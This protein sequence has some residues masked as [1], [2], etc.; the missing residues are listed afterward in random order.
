MKELDIG[1]SLN[2]QPSNHLS[3]VSLLFFLS[4]GFFADFK[5]LEVEVPYEWEGPLPTNANI[6]L[7]WAQHALQDTKGAFA[8]HLSYVMHLR[9]MKINSPAMRD[10]HFGIALDMLTAKLEKCARPGLVGLEGG[11]EKEQRRV[12][13]KVEMDAVRGAHQRALAIQ[14]TMRKA[15]NR[16]RKL[17]GDSRPGRGIG[18]A[19]ATS[20]SKP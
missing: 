15:A 11:E 4:V 1:W 20:S 13:R 16:Q 19:R 10:K 7:V 2:V 14:A 3:W 12:C 18:K 9:D 5:L 8:R 6:G 17:F